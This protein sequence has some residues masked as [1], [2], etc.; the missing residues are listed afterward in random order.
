VCLPRQGREREGEVEVES[1]AT[2]G[3]LDLTERESEEME[4]VA[5]GGGEKES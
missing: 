4:R 1:G 2:T 5:N 3:V